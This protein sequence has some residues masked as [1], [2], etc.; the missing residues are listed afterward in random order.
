MTR[1]KKAAA[2]VAASLM[3]LLVPA[4]FATAAD[5]QQTVFIYGMGAAIDGDAQIG[6]LKVPVDVSIS[7]LFDH[8]KFGAMGAYR[9]ENGTWSFTV[10]ATFMNLGGTSKSEGG[11]LKGEV[12]VEQTTLM[13]TVGRRWTDHLEFL[14]SLAYFDLSNDLKLKLTL[15]ALGETVTRKASVDA[16]WID[17]LVGLQYNVPFA[18]NWRFNLRGDI[19]GFGIGSDL[20]YHVLT[21]FRWQANDTLG[22]VFGYRVIGFDYEDGRKG[23]SNYQRFDLTEQGPVVGVSISF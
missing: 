15:P 19:G 4:S 13:G 22:V 18:G 21:N 16:D 12:G 3:C 10:D 9:A 20:S 5:W 1:N 23:S 7:E 6:D 2:K 11:R 14:V 8:L 17:P